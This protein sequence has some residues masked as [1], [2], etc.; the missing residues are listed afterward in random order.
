[1]LI[2]SPLKASALKTAP[3]VTLAT[4]LVLLLNLTG[5]TLVTADTSKETKSSA[6]SRRDLSSNECLK[7]LDNSDLVI[8]S[9]AF[10]DGLDSSTQLKVQS[11]SKSCE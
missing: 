2:T 7:K 6:S 1:M 9:I 11:T 10:K 8:A 3:A 4:I 5:T